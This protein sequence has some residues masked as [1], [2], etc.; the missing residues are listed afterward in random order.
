MLSHHQNYFANF[1]CCHNC[2][3]VSKIFR[4]CVSLNRNLLFSKDFW[5][6]VVV[7]FRWENKNRKGRSTT[8]ELRDSYFGQLSEDEVNTCQSAH[9]FANFLQIEGH[10]TIISFDLMIL[11]SSDSTSSTNPTSRLLNMNCHQSTW[12][13]FTM[14]L[15]LKNKP[16]MISYDPWFF[17]FKDKLFLDP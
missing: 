8:K 9:S 5:N 10:I 13:A 1:Y 7:W 15:A 6:Y 3:F 11:R 16:K 14:K 2:P 4:M 12:Y 17:S